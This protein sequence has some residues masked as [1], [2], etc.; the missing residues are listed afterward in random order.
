VFCVKPTDT[1][2]SI[3]YDC[4]LFSDAGELQV[5][6]IRSVTDAVVS[7]TESAQQRGDD[8]EG[9]SDGQTMKG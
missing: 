1:L 4:R 7:K 8:V 5:Y 3:D 2:K 9:K 6:T